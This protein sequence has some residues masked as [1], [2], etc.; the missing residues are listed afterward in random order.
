LKE[1][2]LEPREEMRRGE[3]RERERRGRGE[4]G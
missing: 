3:E 1:T 4:G 2:L